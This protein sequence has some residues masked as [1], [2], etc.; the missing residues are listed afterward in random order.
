MEY[1][2][3]KPGW[4]TGWSTERECL[5]VQEFAAGLPCKIL[6]TTDSFHTFQTCWMFTF[7]TSV[8]PIDS[9]CGDKMCGC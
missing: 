3:R 4:L 9:C 5:T 7:P 8:T 6:T 2:E 1:P